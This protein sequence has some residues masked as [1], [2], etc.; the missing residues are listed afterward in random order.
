METRGHGEYSQCLMDG[1]QGES[2]LV[3]NDDN[4]GAGDPNKDDKKRQN[5]DEEQEEAE[6][7]KEKIHEQVDEVLNSVP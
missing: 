4:L 3:A 5:K 2:E 6:E 7:G 1:F